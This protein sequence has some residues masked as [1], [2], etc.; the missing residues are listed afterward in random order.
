MNIE[1]MGDVFD[2]SVDLLGLLREYNYMSVDKDGKLWAHIEVPKLVGDTWHSNYDA[3]FIR[4]YHKEVADWDRQVFNITRLIPIDKPRVASED[5]KLFEEI[6]QHLKIA[7][8]KHPEF[9]DHK[10]FGFAAIAEEGFELFEVLGRQ[11]AKLARAVNDNKSREECIEESKDTIVTLIRLI[12][13]LREQDN[14]GTD[15]DN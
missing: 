12:E 7:R 5:D 14:V 10:G 2:D 15:R 6:K 1:C 8:S 13:T 3:L 9:P 11:M 4:D